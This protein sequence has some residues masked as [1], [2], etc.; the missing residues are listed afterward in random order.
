MDT[1]N[2]GTVLVVIVGATMV[3]KIVTTFE[4]NKE[5]RKGDEMGY[6]KFGASTVAL[7]FKHGKI[8][9]IREEYLQHSVQG[10]E[11]AIKVG[12]SFTN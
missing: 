6:F 1:K 4:P 3:G 2:F 12:Q 8:D 11:T 9:N 10:H 7:L 5:Y